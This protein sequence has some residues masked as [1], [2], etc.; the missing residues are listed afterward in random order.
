MILEP[1]AA[2]AVKRAIDAVYLMWRQVGIA[3]PGIIA[4]ESPPIIFAETDG[5]RHAIAAGSSNDVFGAAHLSA[6]H[7]WPVYGSGCAVKGSVQILDDSGQTEIPGFVHLHRR[8]I[9]VGGGSSDSPESE[10]IRYFFRHRSE[11]SAFYP[12][13]FRRVLDAETYPWRAFRRDPPASS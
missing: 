8:G 13:T 10:T 12:V 7:M 11:Y 6:G 2:S 1:S 4:P 5:T 9:F 3:V